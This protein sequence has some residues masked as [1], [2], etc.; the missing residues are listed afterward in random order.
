M[1]GL[2]REGFI[3][4]FHLMRFPDS[5]PGGRSESLEPVSEL[6]TIDRR[7]TAAQDRANRVV[8]LGE[9]TE[10]DRDHRDHQRLK[11]KRT[12]LIARIR[13]IELD[14]V[15]TELC[16]I[17]VDECLALMLEKILEVDKYAQHLDFFRLAR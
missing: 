1:G 17:V 15:A 4:V 16:N 11:R 5:E 14:T 2:I 7:D 13:G 3:I 12:V 8:A 9:R 6:E 10:A